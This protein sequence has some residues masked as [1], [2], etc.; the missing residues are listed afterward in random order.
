MQNTITLAD[1]NKFLSIDE[2]KEYLIEKEIENV[3]RNS[4]SEHF[5]WLEKKLNVSI[6]DHLN[7]WP[8]FIEITERRNL[9]VHCD[10]VISSQYLSVCSKNNYQFEEEYKIGDVL[11]VDSRYFKNAVNTIYEIGILLGQFIWRKLLPNEI[12]E[13]DR[14]LNEVVFE[15]IVEENYQLAINLLNF[16]LD[17][18]NIQGEYKYMFL[19]NLAQSYKWSGQTDKCLELLDT[20]T[21]APLSNTFKIANYVLRD[22][23]TEAL[24]IMEKI[25]KTNELPKIAYKEWPLFKE[26]VKQDDFKE[27][28][29][30]IYGEVFD[31]TEVTSIETVASTKQQEEHIM[32]EI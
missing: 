12:E 11:D 7:V 9:F 22:D 29:Y 28:H 6:K 32:F 25:S 10:G 2:A 30:K 13:A 31:V 24:R 14:S 27:K 26:F 1:L 3:L 18:W 16:A 23:F 19:I 5:L 20:I 21:W 15:F 8:R 4:H 17:N